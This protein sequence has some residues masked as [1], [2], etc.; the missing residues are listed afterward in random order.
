[1]KILGVDPGKNVGMVA[2]ESDVGLL[3]HTIFTQNETMKYAE[4][5]QFG[6]FDL[7]GIEM[8]G[9][10]GTGM[11][12]GND[13]FDTCIFIGRLLEILKGYKT[14]LVKR[15]EIKMHFCGSMRAK[16]SNIRQALIDR[17]G[18]PGI[19]KSPGLLYGIKSHEWPALAVAVFVGDKNR[20]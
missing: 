15:N 17:F 13:V 10:Y 14:I 2:W 5:I 12:V 9:H 8:I 1:M 6:E 20:D 18:K 3:S 4:E 11:P 16:D 7:I 19:K